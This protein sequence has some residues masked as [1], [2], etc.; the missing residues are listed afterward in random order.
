L[1]PSGKGSQYKII[2]F[3]FE[4]ILELKINFHKSE[5]WCFGATQDHEQ[6][7]RDIFGCK[8]AEIPLRYLGIPI[9][10]RK[11]KNTGWREVEEK[12]EKK[13]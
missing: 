8:K 5:I 4:Q 7:Y 3:V 11:L 9:H 12:F 2:V 1:F 13:A 6:L 10:Y